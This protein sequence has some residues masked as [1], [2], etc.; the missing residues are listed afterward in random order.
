MDIGYLSEK[1]E[2]EGP[3]TISSGEGDSGGISYGSYQLATNEGTVANFVSWLQART[4]C[5][6]GY[7][8]LLAKNPPGS[9]EFS[10]DW[11][12]LANTDE[13]GFGQMQTEFVMPQYYDPACKVAKENGV[14][15]D[16]A[17]DALKCVLFSNAIQHGPRNA[18]EL[19]AESYSND[20]IEWITKVYDTKINDPDWSSGAP[21]LRRG[22]F[23]RWE[24]E[25]QDAIAL[26]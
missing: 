8:D 26:L 19:I 17:P 7:G 22:L 3:A 6:K 21:S 12:S 5:Y 11:L 1:Y 4:D 16:A 24:H 9:R 2:G 25:K 15:M 10:A 20:P 23:N 13:Q 18:G 14:D